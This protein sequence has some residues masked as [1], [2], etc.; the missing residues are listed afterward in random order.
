M[1]AA[2]GAGAPTTHEFSAPNDSTRLDVLVAARLDVSRNQA[3][4]LIANG[5]V[6]IDGRRERASYRPRAGERI[7]VIIPA[8]TSRTVLAEEIPLA[9]VYEDADVLVVDKPAGMVVHPAPGN[10]SGTL[11]NALKG[12]GAQLSPGSSEGREGIVHRLDKETSGLLLVAKTDRAHRVLGAELQARRIVR[13]Y[14]ALAWGHLTEDRLTVE[15]PIA[16]DP[17]DRKRMAIVSKGRP[18]R[19]DFTR[20]ARFDSAD[21]MRAH[22]YTGRTHQIRVHLAAIG[23]PVVGDDTYGGGGG[24]RL[25]QLPPRRHFLHAAWLQFRHPVS[26]KEID[27]RSP[28]PEELRRALAAIAQGSLP[29]DAVAGALDPLEYFGFYRLHL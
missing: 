20:L 22:L 26:G 2:G 1:D 19:T 16:R 3:A 15:K 11:V 6:T 21:L 29:D 8:P 7:T 10:W 4:T 17:R 27:I 25:V 18:A 24:R 14:A 13:R 5:R 28:L 23:H 9:I 12:R